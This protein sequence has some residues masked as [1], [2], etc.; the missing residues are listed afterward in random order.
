MDLSYLPK[1][2][3]EITKR[4]IECYRTMEELLNKGEIELPKIEC[5]WCEIQANKKHVTWLGYLICAARILQMPWEKIEDMIWE[6][7]DS[8]ELDKLTWKDV[9]FKNALRVAKQ[10]KKVLQ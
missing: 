9:N 5:I 8:P 4:A 6:E 10:W 1:R 3:R 7:W 2:E